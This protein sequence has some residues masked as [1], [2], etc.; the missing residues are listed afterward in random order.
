MNRASKLR[1]VMMMI[2]GVNDE[3]NPKRFTIPKSSTSIPVTHHP[4][5]TMRIPNAKH[6]EPLR[7]PGLQ[8]KITTR[9]GPIRMKMPAMN[10]TWAD[11]NTTRPREM[12][13]DERKYRP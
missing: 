11:R 9:C 12:R 5:R 10:R 2:D 4:Q 7:F 3:T 1:A 8:K 13:E 6:A